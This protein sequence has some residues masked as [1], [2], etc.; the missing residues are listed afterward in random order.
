MFAAAD[1]FLTSRSA[2]QYLKSAANFYSHQNLQRKHEFIHPGAYFFSPLARMLQKNF[3]TQS[4]I[5]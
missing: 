2:T 5:L 3:P 1:L 4:S